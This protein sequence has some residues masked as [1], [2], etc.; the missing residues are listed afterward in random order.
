MADYN[1]DDIIKELVDTKVIS[2]K[3]VYDISLYSQ[4][5]LFDKFFKFCQKNLSEVCVDNGYKI[6]PA[7][8]YFTNDYSVNALAGRGQVYSVIKINMGVIHELND[9]FYNNDILDDP[10]LSEYKYFGEFLENALDKT[11]AVPLSFLISQHGSLFT[12][13]HELEHL[14]QFSQKGPF[15]NA[16]TEK[17]EKED[18]EKFDPIKHIEEFDSD[19]HGASNVA[20]HIHDLWIKSSEPDRT[21]ETMKKLIIVSLVG[22]MGY[23]FFL[24]R[25]VNLAMYYDKYKHP[26]PLIRIAWISANIIDTI[27]KNVF[28][29]LSQPEILDETMKILNVY[30]DRKGQGNI[31]KRF[32]DPIKDDYANIIGYCHA[33]LEWSEKIPYLV[34]NTVHKA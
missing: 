5:V 20:F 14:I 22:I 26:H 21:E 9:L 3:D 16:K 32:R 23:I 4:P 2:G 13:Y 24:W 27:Q 15:K 6:A 1:Y 17:Y 29:N 8:M 11:T 18:D 7:R 25:T 19:Q 30:L 34:I 12:Y 33:V 28:P 31:K 10:E